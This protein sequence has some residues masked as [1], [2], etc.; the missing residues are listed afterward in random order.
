MRNINSVIQLS[1]ISIWLEHD[2]WVLTTSTL[3]L[4]FDLSSPGRIPNLTWWYN[5]QEMTATLVIK[6][7]WL[8]IV[9]GDIFIQFY[10]NISPSFAYC[11]FTMIIMVWEDKGCHGDILTVCWFIF[12]FLNMHIFSNCSENDKLGK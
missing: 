10:N 4:D 6:L 2:S 5:E 8:E 1:L 11:I 9:S 7:C 12:L 3:S